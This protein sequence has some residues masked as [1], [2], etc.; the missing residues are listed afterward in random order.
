[1]IKSQTSSE[2]K[3]IGIKNTLVGKLTI[4]YSQ[5]YLPIREISWNKILVLTFISFEIMFSSISVQL[6]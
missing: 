1:M 2:L 4:L 5:N 6:I 3:Y